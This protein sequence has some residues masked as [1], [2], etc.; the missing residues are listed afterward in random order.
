[1]MAVRYFG[2]VEQFEEIRYF[3]FFLVTLAY[4]CGPI[5]ITIIIM[6]KKKKIIIITTRRT[7]LIECKPPPTVVSNSA[8]FNFGQNF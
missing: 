3:F 7:A 1:M 8:T 5:M 2:D 6:I 4:G